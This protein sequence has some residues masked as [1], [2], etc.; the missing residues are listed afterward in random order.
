MRQAL[1]ARHARAEHRRELT[2]VE[3]PPAPL[4]ASIHGRTRPALRAGEH[5]PRRLLHPHVHRLLAFPELAPRHDPRRGQPQDRLVQ[6]PIFHAAPPGWSS[7]PRSYPPTQFPDE[8]ERDAPQRLVDR[9]ADVLA[10]ARDH[11]IRVAHDECDTYWAYGNVTWSTSATV[12]RGA[13]R[14][15]AA[16]CGDR[17]V[18]MVTLSLAR[19]PSSCRL[20][21]RPNSAATA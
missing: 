2:G 13:L 17:P 9:A 11:D 10:V 15:T 19:S 6:L 3:M 7:W 1:H 21:S 14:R 20:G 8:P 18:S 12:A 4:G 16:S 5:R